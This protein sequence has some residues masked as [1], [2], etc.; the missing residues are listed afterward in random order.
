MPFD[1]KEISKGFT[2]D[3]AIIIE[4]VQELT[5][6]GIKQYYIALEKPEWKYETLKELFEE[7]GK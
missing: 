7:I 3:P 2:K 5:L 1:V 6:D 4:K